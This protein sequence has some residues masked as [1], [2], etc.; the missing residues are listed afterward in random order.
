MLSPEFAIPYWPD[1][2]NIAQFNGHGPRSGGLDKTAV[3]HPV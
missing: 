1:L 3:D 2:F